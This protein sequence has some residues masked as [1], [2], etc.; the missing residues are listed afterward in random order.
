MGGQLGHPPRRRPLLVAQARDGRGVQ[1]RRQGV[2]RAALQRG[3]GALVV[4]LKLRA[5][6]GRLRRGGG[7]L[8]RLLLPDAAGAHPD[9]LAL[10]AKGAHPVL[11][12]GQ[13]GADLVDA[14]GDVGVGALVGVD[15]AAGA[16]LDVVGDQGVHDLRRAA[17]V[18][19]GEGNRDHQA[20]VV[21]EHHQRVADRAQHGLV[22]AGGGG[23]GGAGRQH[24]RHQGA[25]AVLDLLHQGR[26]AQGRVELG[27]GVQVQL[28]GNLVQH[29]AGGQRLHLGADPGHRVRRGVVAQ[30]ALQLGDGE[31]VALDGDGA[32]G[33]IDL[34]R[35]AAHA[36]GGDGGGHRGQ[37]DQRQVPAQHA[38]KLLQAHHAGRP[39]G[40]RGQRG[41]NRD[42]HGALFNPVKRRAAC[43]GPG[44]QEAPP[45]PAPPRR[46]RRAA[47]CSASAGARRS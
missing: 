1:H 10:A 20:A 9:Q 12:P 21:A 24:R 36:V 16:G 30:R 7:Q 33:G 2:R 35:R 17:R 8:L 40:G 22:R 14:L 45:R 31:A 38:R 27:V 34:R 15:A 39:R 19:G 11:D 5:V 41:R 23:V 25:D 42:V 43:A 13:V 44:P 6:H 18:L 26:R 28:G 32:A 29:R 3:L 37:R 46:G 4:D 47:A